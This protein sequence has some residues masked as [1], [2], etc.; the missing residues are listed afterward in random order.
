M[1]SLMRSSSVMGTAHN[2]SVAGALEG[3]PDDP[4]VCGIRRSRKLLFLPTAT[5]YASRMLVHRG[6]GTLEPIPL[7]CESV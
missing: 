1:I 3:C 2:A 5:C 7:R 6:W 4:R